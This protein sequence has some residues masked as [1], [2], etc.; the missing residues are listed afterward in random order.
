MMRKKPMLAYP[1]SDKPIDYSKPMFIQPK[2]DGVRCVIQLNKFKICGCDATEIVAY[3]RTGKE[4]KNVEHI[5]VEL[6]PFFDKFPNVISD[7]GY[8]RGLFRSNEIKRINDVFSTVTA[9]KS[10]FG[11]I[12]IKSRSRLGQY[13][14]LKKFPSMK[15]EHKKTTTTI[16]ISSKKLIIFVVI[17]FFLINFFFRIT[18]F[19]IQIKI[20]SSTLRIIFRNMFLPVGTFSIHQPEF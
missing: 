18:N 16:M 8:I 13:D 2:L 1:V 9:P 19:I 17:L 12:K 15:G 4:W 11:L 20:Y 5:L 6:M 14:L 10:L 3:S 7:D